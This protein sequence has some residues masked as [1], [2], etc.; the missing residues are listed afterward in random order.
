MLTAEQAYVID[1]MLNN[2]KC[3]GRLHWSEVELIQNFKL[4]FDRQDNEPCIEQQKLL[5][6]AWKKANGKL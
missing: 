2:E 3:R 5:V 6:M 1:Q 4:R